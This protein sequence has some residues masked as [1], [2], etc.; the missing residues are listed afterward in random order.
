LV[1][2]Q[3]F[4][5]AQSPVNEASQIVQRPDIVNGRVHW[6]GVR[7]GCI[8]CRPWDLVVSLVVGQ[9]RV[10]TNSRGELAANVRVPLD[11]YGL[12]D[13]HNPSKTNFRLETGGRRPG[14][15][16]LGLGSRGQF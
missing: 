7:L 16:P 4:F 5:L 3:I 12:A 9:K 1:V 10:S 11:R 15:L 2:E 6:I 13:A 8:G 14:L